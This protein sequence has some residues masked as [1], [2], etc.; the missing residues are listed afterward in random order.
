[1][2]VWVCVC[3]IIHTHTNIYTHIY[4]YIYIYIYIAQL[5]LS[6]YTSRYSKYYQPNLIKGISPGRETYVKRNWDQVTTYDVAVFRIT[7]I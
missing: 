7:T 5:V 2:C 4:I 6:E 3:A 1:M